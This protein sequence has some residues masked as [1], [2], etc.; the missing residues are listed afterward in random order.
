[1]SVYFFQDGHSSPGVREPLID[2]SQNI[3]STQYQ[4][5]PA[6]RSAAPPYTPSLL[7]PPYQ[8][9][10]INHTPQPLSQS[11]L[12]PHHAT[13]GPQS[14]EQRAVT[15]PKAYSAEAPSDTMGQ[16]EMDTTYG[17]MDPALAQ[18]RYSLPSPSQSRYFPDEEAELQEMIDRMDQAFP[19]NL[20]HSCEYGLICL[21]YRISR[22]CFVTGQYGSTSSS[23]FTKIIMNLSFTPL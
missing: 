17:N 4:S 9:P 8:A 20:S 16:L 14:P 7:P 19:K 6:S 23:W 15:T 21:H 3:P 2:I 5:T 18:T 1:M 13:E 22:H 10:P 11:L 12:M